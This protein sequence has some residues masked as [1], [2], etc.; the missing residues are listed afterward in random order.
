[1]GRP[2]LSSEWPEEEVGLQ[3]GNQNSEDKSQQL[4]ERAPSHPPGPL[5]HRGLGT[6]KDFPGVG[7][8]LPSAVGPWAC[9]GRLRCRS[10]LPRPNHLK[11][12]CDEM[13]SVGGLALSSKYL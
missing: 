10:V 5:T 11:D 1:M 4:G 8:F 13:S 9:E 2:H 6:S 7:S 3:T 12:G